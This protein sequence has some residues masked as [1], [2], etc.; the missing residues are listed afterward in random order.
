MLAQSLKAA[1]VAKG[2]SQE[3]LAKS[4]G[5]SQQAVNQYEK[6][7]VVPSLPTMIELAKALGITIDE[8]VK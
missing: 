7:L 6:G 4:V 1:R 3:Q 8:L 5:I 2:I